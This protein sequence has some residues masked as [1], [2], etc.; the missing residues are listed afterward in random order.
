MAG[1]ARAARPGESI[2]SPMVPEITDRHH[3]QMEADGFTIFEGVFSAD[4][5]RA[6]DCVLETFFENHRKKLKAQGGTD[7]I[8]RADEILFTYGIA[9]QDE[10]VAA[11]IK[12][13]EFVALSTAFL[14]PNTDLYWNQT[15]YKMPEGQKEFP[16]HQDDG[17]I[18]VEPSPY[19]TLWL[20]IED[21]DEQNGC[22]RVLPGS[23]KRGLLPH[24]ESPIGL[25]CYDNEAPDQGIPVPLR[26]GSLACFWSLTV[27]KSGPN[28]S[29]GVRKGYVIQ[30]SAE[31][32]R[33]YGQADP[34]EGKLAVA[35]SGAAV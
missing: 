3:Q 6:L 21:A 11:F 23:H 13:P 18:R 9:E 14:G 32:L 26:Q 31:G 34:I 12:R 7:F 15:V 10:R 29:K 22:I 17:Y 28:R 4:E 20:A 2:L 27:H 19:L 35:R 5:M 24:S 1:N 16:W 8:N 33:H 30:Y 25:V